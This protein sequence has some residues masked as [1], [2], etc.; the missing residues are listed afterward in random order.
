MGAGP[1][2]EGGVLAVT[3]AES[4]PPTVGDAGA[5][6]LP[7]QDVAALAA[8][9]LQ[10]MVSEETAGRSVQ[11]SSQVLAGGIVSALTR[12]ARDAALLVLGNSG[13]E[14]PWGVG[15]VGRRCA[16]RV[17]CPTVWVPPDASAPDEQVLVV[18]VGHVSRR[19]ALGRRRSRGDR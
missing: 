19:A 18:G 15:S 17:D 7:P 6:V 12:Q 4:S 1:H 11:V 3:V 8:S 16:R 5:V 10:G 13:E 2:D 9:E 14:R